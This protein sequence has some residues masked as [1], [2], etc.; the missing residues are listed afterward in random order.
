MDDSL[1]QKL[2]ERIA[3]LQ[4]QIN[5]LAQLQDSSFG[6]QE[7]LWIYPKPPERIGEEGK[8]QMLWRSQDK[9]VYPVD[10][11][12]G[13]FPDGQQLC[14]RITNIALTYT[15]EGDH[16]GAATRLFFQVAPNLTYSIR[17]GG[18]QTLAS[19]MMLGAIA[20]AEEEQLRGNLKIQFKPGESKNVVL[21]EVHDSRGNLLLPTG[22]GDARPEKG[23]S[24]TQNL[25]KVEPLVARA[26]GKFFSIFPYA[27]YSS[28]EM[29]Q[30]A[31]ATIRGQRKATWD[32][33]S[34]DDNNE[35]ALPTQ[36][37]APLSPPSANSVGDREL[38][39]L[40]PLF[41]QAGYNSPPKE[42]ETIIQQHIETHGTARKAAGYTL[43]AIA[44]RRGV[45]PSGQS[46]TYVLE[47][48]RQNQEIGRAFGAGHY[49]GVLR[50]F[51]FHIDQVVKPGSQGFDDIPF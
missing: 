2:L 28:E 36:S 25:S 1:A 19:R 10:A 12:T 9:V 33:K 5:S 3:D 20:N 41:I 22:A 45:A 48:I 23:V 15:E 24:D 32:S 21:I 35:Q 40:I 47:W 4:R 39:E 34:Q 13:Y 37:A 30:R 46:T 27:E 29:F 50:D 14:G 16:P 6:V 8:V 26:F 11:Y 42:L 49:S 51:L 7:T 44:E 18:V 17:L 43:A 38:E 31:I